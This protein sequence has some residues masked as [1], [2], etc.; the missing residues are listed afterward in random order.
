M[1]T[2]QLSIAPGVQIEFYPSVGIL[3]LG[4]LFARGTFEAPITMRPITLQKMVRYSLLKEVGV[5]PRFLSFNYLFS[6]AGAIGDLATIE[7]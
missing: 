5:P 1:P 4:P 7:T 3:A 6:F 2:A